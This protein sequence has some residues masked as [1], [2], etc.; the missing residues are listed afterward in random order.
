MKRFQLVLLIVLLIAVAGTALGVVSVIVNDRKQPSR[1]A[2][3]QDDEGVAVP[4]EQAVF[5]ETKAKPLKRPLAVAAGPDGRVYV[6][7]TGNNRVVVFDARRQ[8]TGG[9]RSDRF[10]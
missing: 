8:K 5:T 6:T 10:G 9:V 4:R 3:R 1:P 7:D 2:M